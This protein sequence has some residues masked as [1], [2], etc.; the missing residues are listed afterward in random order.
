MSRKARI[1]CKIQ[2]LQKDTEGRIEAVFD[3][4]L[5]AGTFQSIPCLIDHITQGAAPAAQFF[6][7]LGVEVCVFVCMC[8][9]VCVC[10]LCVSMRYSS[11]KEETQWC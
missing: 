8:V 3:R 5:E 7:G 11:N 4:Q 9:C 2:V 1:Q 6:F 10:K